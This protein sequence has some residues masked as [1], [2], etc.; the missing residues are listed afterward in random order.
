MILKKLEEDIASEFCGTKG[1]L[2]SDGWTYN[3]TDYI[4][5][6]ANYIRKQA[7][8]PCVSEIYQDIWNLFS[9]PQA[10]CHCC[11]VMIIET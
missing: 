4:G 2:Q 10:L 6:F 3:G 11:Q 5:F 8:V 1:A 7:I 9:Y